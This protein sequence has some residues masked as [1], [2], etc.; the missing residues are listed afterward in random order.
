MSRLALLAGLLVLAASAG[1]Q[2]FARD[3]GDVFAGCDDRA[4][5]FA[6]AA[7]PG[8]PE[9]QAAPRVDRITQRSFASLSLD[10]LDAGV[11]AEMASLCWARLDG[12]WRETGTITLDRS[13]DDPGIWG[14]DSPELVSMA[15]G[16][17]TT[18]RFLVVVETAD[19]TTGLHLA[20]GLEEAPF[21]RFVSTDGLA[22]R[23]V[24]QRLGPVKT[25]RAT[26]PFAY[27]A[28]LTLDVTR[29]GSVRLTLDGA[30]FVRPEPSAS[31]AGADSRV[32]IDDSWLLSAYLM[33]VAANRRGYD[34]VTQDP[35]LLLQNPKEEIL[36]PVD[37]TM[38]SITEGRTV[39]VG[40]TLVQDGQQGTVYRKS[41]VASET[42]LQHTSTHTFG[43][44]YSA[45]VPSTKIPGVSVFEASAGYE[46]TQASMSSMQESKSVAQAAAY[47]RHKQYALVLDH[48][49]ITLSS[50]FIDAVEDARR[51]HRYQA[52]I[53]RFGT[54][55]PYAVTYGASAKM[56]QLFTE[57]SYAQQERSE[58]GFSEFGGAKVFGNGGSAHHSQLAGQVTG[59]R[60]TVGNEGATFVA[61]G[62]NG[63]WDQ[64]GYSAGGTPYPILLDL[65][66]IY[67]LLNPMNF[68]GEPE[69]YQ[70]VRENLKRAVVA[71]LESNTTALSS[72]SMLPKVE[73]LPPPAPPP[74]RQVRTKVFKDPLVGGRWLDLCYAHGGCRTQQALNAF[75]RL[76][77]YKT[78]SRQRNNKSKLGH[79]NVRIGDNSKCTSNGLGNCR[80][81][82]QVTCSD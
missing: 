55:Y 24:L 57:E 40:L 54:H 59:S 65:R 45:N 72:D 21:V 71:Y 63:S 78:G 48:P 79:V 27:G 26:G 3:P 5:S 49:Y 18:P 53:D 23:D 50:A 17:Y 33:N 9:V 67:E 36:A 2:D 22:L 10:E 39:P 12:V 29:S 52:L 1:A 31:R 60:G 34:I 38:Y 13:R 46:S 64:G 77:G 42:E 8:A 69:V 28:T 6:P 75:C 58:E 19:P 32:R 81:I 47:S 74:P 51:F 37:P 35:F 56:T 73:P 61:V 44:S 16:N 82:T 30:M 66:P 15:N 14:S 20:T 41:L 11:P 4:A 43:K 62:G 76:Q 68:P 7:A 25:Y 80:R 70:R